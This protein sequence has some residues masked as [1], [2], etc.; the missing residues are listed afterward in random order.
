MSDELYLGP[1]HVNAQLAASLAFADGASGASRVF[2]YG[3]LPDLPR[4][5]PS[6]EYSVEIV[7]A[8]PCATL[9]GESLTLIPAS[10]TGSMVQTTGLARWAR[11]VRSDGKLVAAGTVSNLAGTGAFRI[12]GGTTPPGEDTPLLQAGGLVLFGALILD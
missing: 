10:A 7:L 1:E 8:K 3:S 11:W 5:I 9:S 2:L 6:A 12:A 4:A